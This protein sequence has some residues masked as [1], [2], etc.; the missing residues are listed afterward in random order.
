[1]LARKMRTFLWAYRYFDNFSTYVALRRGR[2]KSAHCLLRTKDG[3]SL[4][5]RNNR[6]DVRIV[7]ET[8]FDRVYGAGLRNVRAQHRPVVVDIGGYIGD[9]SLYAAKYLDATVIVYEP[10]PENYE[11]LAEN[12]RLNPWADLRIWNR[13]VAATAEVAINLERDGNDLHA[14]SYLYNRTNEK[15]VVPASRLDDV[16]AEN[17]VERI[18]LLKIDCEGGEYDILAT[19]RDETFDRIENIVLEY[20]GIEDWQRKLDTM[21]DRLRSQAYSVQVDSDR[22]ILAAHRTTPRIGAGC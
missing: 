15:I 16:F 18:D 1:M 5:C 6:W 11:L 8:F 17:D 12:S 2:A 7:T 10:V 9:F 14:S 22:C 20:H 13:A 3:I 19:A 4:R 21:L